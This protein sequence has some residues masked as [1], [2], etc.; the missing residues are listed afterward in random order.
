MQGKSLVACGLLS[1]LDR[2]YGME[3]VERSGGRL[4][5]GT[6]Y[7]LLLRLARE[8]LVASEQE[9]D[10]GRPGTPRRFWWLT[11]HGKRVLAA[12]RRYDTFCKN[13]R[14]GVSH[15]EEPGGMGCE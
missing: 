13:S 6:V 5:K 12:R 10:G 2:A 4:K 8:G 14:Y 15:R 7:V 11:S 3:L 9:K 1:D